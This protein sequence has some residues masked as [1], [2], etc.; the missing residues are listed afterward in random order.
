LCPKT[1]CIPNAAD[2]GAFREAAQ[3]RL[4]T[5]ADIARIKGPK[6]GFI[7]HI[8]YWIDLKL[9]RFLAERRP[10][11]SFVL[12]GPVSPLARL[13]VV[14]SLSNVHLLGRK[15]EELIPAYVQAFDCCL[16]PYVTGSLADHCSPLKL[17]EYL[18]AGKPIVSTE[19][20]EARK[21]PEDVKIAVSYEEFQQFC[22]DVI[23]ALPESRQVIDTRVRNAAPHSWLS[24]FNQLNRVLKDALISS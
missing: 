8:Q 1:F 3:G 22:S 12:V 11:W 18:A 20:P 7:G 14:K 13:D 2:V 4:E 15:P 23:S 5:P 24:R 10:D 19:M 6:L 21:F 17:Y 16:N 9:I